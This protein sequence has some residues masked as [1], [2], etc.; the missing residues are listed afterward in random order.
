[1]LG[2]TIIK[3]S[4]RILEVYL[5]FYFLVFTGYRSQL[6]I[7]DV[8]RPMFFIIGVL[9]ALLLAYSLFSREPVQ[10]PEIGTAGIIFIV[11]LITSTIH[12]VIKS[13]AV[14][15]LLILTLSG[16]VFLGIYNLAIYSG[17]TIILR[18]ELLI[19]GSVYL[20]VKLAQV[21]IWLPQRL[22]TCGK[23]MTAANKTAAV[24]GVILFLAIAELIRGRYKIFPLAVLIVASVLLSLTGS[25]GGIIA[26]AAGAIIQLYYYYWRGVIGVNSIQVGSA[27][28]FIMLWAA[29]VIFVM[30]PVHCTDLIT[31]IQAERISGAWSSSLITRTELFREAGKII[32]WRPLFGS[33]PGTTV[34]LLRPVF[35]PAVMT[36]HAHNLYLQMAAERGIIGLAALLASAA[37][38]VSRLVQSSAPGIAGSALAAM[39]AAAVHGLVDVTTIEPIV[40]RFILVVLALALA[41]DKIAGSREALRL[42]KEK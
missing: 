32:L 23:Y 22:N 24:V 13:V 10:L 17:D 39:A 30:R 7:P 8:T 28:F 6:A 14:N 38:I 19:T 1:M 40:L 27:A 16:L 26:A 25:R 3:I 37:V 18:M 42:P 15:E 31:G 41:G 21:I 36:P 12:A 33:G 5:L 11:A 9:L 2:K 34:Y 20:A 35:P 29:L 4:R